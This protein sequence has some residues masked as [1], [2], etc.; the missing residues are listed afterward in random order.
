M[1][2]L[3]GVTNC[4]GYDIRKPDVCVNDNNKAVRLPVDYYSDVNAHKCMAHFG[5]SCDA[6]ADYLCEE[7][8]LG[9]EQAQGKDCFT[10][11][12]SSGQHRTPNAPALL[13]HI[14]IL[15]RRGIP[16]TQ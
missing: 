3:A 14:K 13:T 8:K 16:V 1:R 6:D 9:L 10:R 5:H 2:N 4:V 7:V 15:S 11:D 12:Q